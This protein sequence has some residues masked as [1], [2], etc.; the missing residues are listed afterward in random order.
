MVSAA[1]LLFMGVQSKNLHLSDRIR[2]AGR[3]MPAPG[4]RPGVPASP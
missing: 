1:G 2:G 4:A 3:G